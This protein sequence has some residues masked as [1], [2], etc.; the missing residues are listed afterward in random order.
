MA[1]QQAAARIGAPNMAKNNSDFVNL[2]VR[3]YFVDI[4]GASFPQ[5]GVSID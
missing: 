3:N 2:N 1:D 5:D 4:D